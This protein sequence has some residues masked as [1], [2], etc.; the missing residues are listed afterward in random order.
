MRTARFAALYVLPSGCRREQGQSG[1]DAATGR[2]VSGIAVLW[3]P[4]VCRAAGT[5]TARTHQPKTRATTDA[6]HGHRGLV[7]EAESESSGSWTRDLSLSAPR[8]PGQPTQP[9]LEH[10][11]HL[12]S[13]AIRVPLPGGHYG[14]VQPL[15]VELGSLQYHGGGLLPICAG[16]GFARRP[17]R[18]LQLRSRCAIYLPPVLAATQGSLH[19]NQYGWAR[20]SHGQRVYRAA[21]ALGEIRTDLSRRLRFRPRT[22]VGLSSLFRPLQFPPAA[23]GIGLSYPGR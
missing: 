16:G 20:A 1:V 2:T 3:K 13:D 15:R 17:V 6:A 23:S 14:L 11:Y 4:Q 7:P 18:D 8:C 10:R 22:V 19:S 21:V 5:R 9:G 12:P